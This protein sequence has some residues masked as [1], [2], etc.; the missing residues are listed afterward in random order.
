MRESDRRPP[1]WVG[2]SALGMAW[3]VVLTAGFGVMHAYESTPGPAVSAPDDWP[4]DA[5]LPR[6]PGVPNVVM[7]VH[8]RCPCSRASLAALGDAIGRS[9][10]SASVRLLVF[11]PSDRGPGWGDGGMID[12]PGAVR[13]DDPGGAMA[14]RFGLETSGATAAFDASGRKR[15]AGGLTAA[16][17]SEGVSSGAAAIL[18]T[19]RGDAPMRDAAEVFGCP[20]RAQNERDRSRGSQP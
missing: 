10:A 1:G 18:A 5:G 7:A 11:R 4:D 17:G 15:F 13:V 12:V 9:R 19:L 2:L 20:M 14:R 6:V 16:R 3:L 8:P